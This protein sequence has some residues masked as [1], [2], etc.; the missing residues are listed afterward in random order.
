[1]YSGHLDL[2]EWHC[3]SAAGL[4]WFIGATDHERFGNVLDK[5]KSQNTKEDKYVSAHVQVFCLIG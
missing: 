4:E 1:M 3:S 5:M 2:R